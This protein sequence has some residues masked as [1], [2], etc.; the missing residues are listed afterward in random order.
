MQEAPVQAIGRPGPPVAPGH[1]WV[2]AV[3]PGPAGGAGK[4]P[5]P[6]PPPRL[7][8]FS[9]RGIVG[10]AEA[11]ADDYLEVGRFRID[12]GSSMAWSHP[13]I[14]AG[15]LILRHHDTIYAYDIRAER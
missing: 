12:S 2:E 7:S 13:I 15:R 9:E 1:E 11:T 4:G 14:S 8:L 6:P 3:P 10:L 5:P